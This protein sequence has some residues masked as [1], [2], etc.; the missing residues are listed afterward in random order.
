MCREKSGSRGRNMKPKWEGGYIKH[1]VRR[2]MNWDLRVNS[3]E[4]NF[5]IK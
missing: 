4:E 3:C 2:M 1:G 5:G